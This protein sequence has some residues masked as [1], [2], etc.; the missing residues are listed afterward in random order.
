MGFLFTLNCPDYPDALALPNIPNLQL[1]CQVGLCGPQHTMSQEH[2]ETSISGEVAS[3]YEP[4]WN[5]RFAH[6]IFDCAIENRIT[7][8]E[9]A[10]LR[11]TIP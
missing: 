6:G 8:R 5:Q 1:P 7:A 10:M 3:A 11:I 2:N 9:L 4:E